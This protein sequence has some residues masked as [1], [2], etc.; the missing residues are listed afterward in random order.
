MFKLQFYY[1]DSDFFF[2]LSLTETLYID[3]LENLLYQGGL[4][5]NIVIEDG[6][7][8]EVFIFIFIFTFWNITLVINC[9]STQLINHLNYECLVSHCMP[10]SWRVVVIVLNR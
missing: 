3:D 9:S 1:D 10:K 6:S 2:S 5:I 4:S 7:D 8:E